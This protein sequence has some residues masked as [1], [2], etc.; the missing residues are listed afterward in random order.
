MT[1]PGRPHRLGPPQGALLSL[2]G[3]IH[4]SLTM[5]SSNSSPN[6]TPNPHLEQ[7]ILKIV[8]ISTVLPTP[9]PDRWPALP[10]CAQ[11]MWGHPPA[12]PLM[13][14]ELSGG[15]E[16]KHTFAHLLPAVSPRPRAER[17]TRKPANKSQIYSAKYQAMSGTEAIK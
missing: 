1:Q 14:G 6:P 10:P 4:S 15:P 2:R 8:D 11:P 13:V 9:A 16:P 3:S 5:G 7:T 12:G 17:Y